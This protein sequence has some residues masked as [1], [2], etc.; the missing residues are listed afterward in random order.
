MGTAISKA[1]ERLGADWDLGNTANWEANF[2]S[3]CRASGGR[4]MY[5]KD[6]R[7]NHNDNPYAGQH[8]VGKN[9]AYLAME[10]EY[11]ITDT[12][13]HVSV[14][15]GEKRK[16]F[17]TSPPL[18]FNSAVQMD[19]SLRACDQA[20]GPATGRVLLE[21]VDAN[22]TTVLA[23]VQVVGPNKLSRLRGH[24]LESRIGG[25]KIVEG[26][27]R[28]PETEALFTNLKGK[29]LRAVIACANDNTSEIYATGL[30]IHCRRIGEAVP[31]MH[32]VSF[33]PLPVEPAPVAVAVGTTPPP[34][35]KPGGGLPW[36]IGAEGNGD[37][38]AS[39]TPTSTATAAAPN[40]GGGGLSAGAMVGIIALVLILLTVVALLIHRSRKTD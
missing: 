11:C 34:G 15:Q 38:G 26:L 39:P 37:G 12:A 21:L 8:G 27:R 3:Y 14:S 19:I 13:S 1:R 24:P 33:P 40:G 23:S 31:P 29:K 36:I 4:V 30:Q 25:N 18:T 6:Y 10:I 17:G 7:V 20:S 32:L 16:I 9:E 28:S 35:P 5:Y 2:L 22:E